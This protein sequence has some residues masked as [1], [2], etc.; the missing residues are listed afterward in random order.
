METIKKTNNLTFTAEYAD[1]DVKKIEEGILFEFQGD[2][3]NLHLGTDRK[4]CIFATAEAV[5]ET[6]QTFGLEEEFKQYLNYKDEQEN[7]PKSFIDEVYE[8]SKAHGWWDGEERKF[9][10]LI[11]LCH[12][13]LSEAL[14]EYR[15][16]HAPTETYYGEKGKPEG[17]PT[18]LADVIIRICDMCGHYGIDIEKAITEKHEF[19]KSRPYKH[20]GKII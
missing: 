3:I 17:I 5:C 1:G 7:A 4:E 6:V 11:A 18:E 15:N 13:E 2:R 14:E 16:G 12:A 19:N 20:G 10:E 8:N 9:G